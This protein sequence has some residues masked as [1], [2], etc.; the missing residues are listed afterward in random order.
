M[1]RKISSLATLVVVLLVLIVPMFAF[2]AS[3]ADTE[4]TLSF[5]ST[6]QRTSFSTSQQVWEQNG[7]IFTNDKASSTTAVADY[8]K[9]A[10]LYAGSS[11]EIEAPGNITKIVFDCNSTSYATAMKNS[12][13]GTASASSDK[14]TVTLDGS[15]NS[16]NVAKLTAQVRLDSIT[17]TYNADDAACPHEN[18][19]KEVTKKASCT[20]PGSVTI[21]CIDCGEE[22]GKEA[23]E[24]LGHN[25]VY[26]ECTRCKATVQ[27]AELITSISS[28]KVGDQIILVAKGYNV[29][30]STEQKTNNRAETDIIKENSEM[31]VLFDKDVQVITI[32]KGAVDGTFALYTDSGYLYAASSN[33]NH[34]RTEQELSANSSW[35][36]TIDGDGTA[37]LVANGENARKS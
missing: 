11:V 20:E 9:P 17:V 1:K 6:A 19:E 8:A 15:S 21:K 13:G 5:A 10:R 22:V 14:V 24:A 4:A 23:I 32:E 29:A 30:V 7:I 27:L 36:I 16:F 34:L 33:D 31:N 2:T 28:L 25:Y 18:K 26:N 12:I 3:A 35:S 37:T